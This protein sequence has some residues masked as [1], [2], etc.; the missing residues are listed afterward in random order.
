MAAKNDKTMDT[1]SELPPIRA[2]EL[3]MILLDHATNGEP[4]GIL[5]PPGCGKTELVHQVAIE[6]NKPIL[7]PFNAVLSDGVDAK[8][9]PAISDDGTAVT[10]IKEKRWL[11]PYATTVL[12]DELPQ[13][14]MG[15]INSMAS[16][17]YEKRIDDIFLHKDTW[18][19]WTG[20]RAQD[21]CGTTRMPSHV[22]N[23]SYLYEMAVNAEDH[24]AH[25][26]NT[27]NVDML[28]LR[29]LRMKGATAYTF[30]P[31]MTVN[32]TPRAWS[33]I[34]RKLGTH[35][36]LPYSVMAGRI[37]RGLA[38]ELI[39]FRDIAPTLPS[40]EEVLT[41][42]TKARVPDNVSALF[43]VTDMLADKASAVSFDALVT[44]AK[45]LPPE[46]Q[47][48]FVKDSIQRNP[49]VASTKAFVSWGVQFAE[50][51]R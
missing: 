39:A 40:P 48:K 50:A 33:T 46:M 8:G 29:F 43:L 51:L 23:R 26:I 10:W 14:N 22:N 17:I 35:P 31:A 30:D 28:T 6:V 25:E 41:N 37:G 32:A 21:K 18:V 47:A 45:R 12:I 9:L 27:P 13:G 38:T 36:K 11:V 49:E 44:Y 2:K 15:S 42:P 1:D 19:V 20:N 7:S 16:V 24:I 3:R 4:V 34:A 5:G